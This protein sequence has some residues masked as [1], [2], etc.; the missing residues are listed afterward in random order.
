M[1]KP[2]VIALGFFDG[3]HRGHG[4]LLR[5]AA[6]R[7]A[8]LGVE[9]AVFTFDRPP[10]E[11]VTGRTVHLINSAEDRRSL[12]E[13]LYGIDRVIFAPFDDNMMHCSWQDFLTELLIRENGAV[14]L[15]AGHDY[16]FG[17][18]NE[19]NPH[20]LQ[21]AC[22]RLGLG[23]DII[24]KVELD[25][26]T[27]SSTYIRTL[28]EQGDMERAAEFLGHPHCLSQTVRHGQHFGRTIGIPTVNLEVPQGVLVPRH[29]VYITRV[30][31]PDGRTCPGITNVGV[32]PTVSQ[33]GLVTVETFLLDFEGNLYDQ[34]L[35]LEFF[36]H[37][38]DEQ[39]FADAEALKTQI[40]KDIASARAYFAKTDR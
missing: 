38:R 36:R 29:G 22:A 30:C 21:E 13:R 18:K 8:E 3:V 31:L 17:Y 40:H 7:A 2:S 33:S 5:K 11:V 24:P 28:V 15:V 23:C 19:G 12:M 35:R 6:Q 16:H 14:H 9:S 1:N 26:I 37:L 10:K 4:A 27:V 39:R 20:L 34:H 32:R 25:G